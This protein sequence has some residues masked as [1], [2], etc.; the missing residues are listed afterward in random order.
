[1]LLSEKQIAWVREQ[2][3]GVK[4]GD[5]DA[6]VIWMPTIEDLGNAYKDFWVRTL[7]RSSA[8]WMKRTGGLRTQEAAFQGIAAGCTQHTPMLG[9]IWICQR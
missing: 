7:R 5:L 4:I 1:M 8:R 9:T 2:L 3:E 6:L